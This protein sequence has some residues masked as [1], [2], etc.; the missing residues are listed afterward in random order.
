[1]EGYKSLGVD[2][3]LTLYKQSLQQLLPLL[4]EASRGRLS[5]DNQRLFDAVVSEQTQLLSGIGTVS[6]ELL[7]K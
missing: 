3:A 2:G 1:M 4:P 7:M 6:P 5:A